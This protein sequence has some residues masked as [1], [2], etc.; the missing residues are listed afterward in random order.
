MKLI[1]DRPKSGRRLPHLIT[2]L[3]FAVLFIVAPISL[4]R[5]LFL[6]CIPALIVWFLVFIFFVIYIFTKLLRNTKEE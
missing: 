5:I 3:I 6:E 4:A 1:F 2:G